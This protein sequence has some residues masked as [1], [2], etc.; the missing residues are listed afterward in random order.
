VA[1]NGGKLRI[2]NRSA[3]GA[4]V[5]LAFPEPEKVR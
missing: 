1:Q 4:E 3:G 5:I 2:Q